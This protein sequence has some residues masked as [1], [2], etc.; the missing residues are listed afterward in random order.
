MKPLACRTCRC[1]DPCDFAEHLA[2]TIRDGDE[3][4]QHDR[5]QML[6]EQAGREE[7]AMDERWG[8]AS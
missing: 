7:R 8:F 2:E 6:D 5:E 4:S 1:S 3:Y